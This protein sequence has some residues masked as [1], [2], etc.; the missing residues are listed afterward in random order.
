LRGRPR[1]RRPTGMAGGGDAEVERLRVSDGDAAGDCVVGIL[2]LN[3]ITTCTIVADA[4]GAADRRRRRRRRRRCG[5]ISSSESE[6]LAAASL[7]S[8]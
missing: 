7:F 3:G 5:M 1:P 4:E 8:D 2:T 6:T